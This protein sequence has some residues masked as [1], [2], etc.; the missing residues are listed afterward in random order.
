MYIKNVQTVQRLFTRS[1]APELGGWMASQKA[2]YGEIKEN[3][4]P[5]LN[6]FVEKMKLECMYLSRHREQVSIYIYFSPQA[7]ILR[8]N[9]HNVVVDGN[10]S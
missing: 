6:L 7:S 10:I 5:C 8:K 1:I 9:L 2:G 3:Q 4:T